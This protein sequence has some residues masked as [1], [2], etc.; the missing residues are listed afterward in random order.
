MNFLVDEQLPESLCRFLLSKGFD[1]VHVNTLRSGQKMPDM[2]I[3]ERSMKESRVV[4]SKDSDF[5]KRFLLLR[6]PHKLL[7]LT[8]GNIKNSDLLL[9]FEA[10]FPLILRELTHNNVVEMNQ[11]AIVV[12]A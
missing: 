1:A 11:R 12:I 5:L 3:C 2:D 10:N 6:E 9:L 7:F 4:I 8:T